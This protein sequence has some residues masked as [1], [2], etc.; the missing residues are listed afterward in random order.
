MRSFSHLWCARTWG[1]K[2][3]RSPKECAYAQHVPFGEEG[4]G[5]TYVQFVSPSVARTC[6][7]EGG[8]RTCTSSPKGCAY[9]HGLDLCGTK[10]GARCTYSKPL[11]KKSRTQPRGKGRSTTFL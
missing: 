6:T 2:H 5:R 7:T 3:N 8:A 1:S 10:K 11:C 4:E 9:A